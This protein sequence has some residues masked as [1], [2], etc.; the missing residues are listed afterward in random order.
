MNVRRLAASFQAGKQ[1]LFNHCFSFAQSSL[2]KQLL[3]REANVELLQTFVRYGL[4]GY[5][6]GI[7]NDLADAR[8][9]LIPDKYQVKQKERF[10]FLLFHME[11]NSI[12]YK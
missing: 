5:V 1:D 4:A 12:N 8:G 10:H 3:D 2:L 11:M 9:T 6:T 7:T